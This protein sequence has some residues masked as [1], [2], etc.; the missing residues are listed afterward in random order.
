MAQFTS[1]YG[2]V[3]NKIIYGITIVR[4]LILELLAA[5]LGWQ[6]MLDGLFERSS[7]WMVVV[8]QEFCQVLD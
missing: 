6:S 7:R 1:C 3:G 8:P 4:Q 2:F 5:T